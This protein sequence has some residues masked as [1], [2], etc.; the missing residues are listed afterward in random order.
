MLKQD[1]ELPGDEAGDGASPADLTAAVRRARLD[2]EQRGGIV[3]GLRQGEFARLDLLNARLRPVFAQV[4]PD[5]DIFDHGIVPGERPRCYID[6]LAFVEMERDRQ[7]YCFSVDTRRGR[8]TVVR[9]EQVEIIVAQVTDYV[10]RRLVE[11]ERMMAESRVIVTP[12]AGV[13]KEPV[14]AA[15]LAGPATPAPAPPGRR[16]DAGDI[17]FAIIMGLIGGAA[18]F[19]G[20]LW[21]MEWA[22]VARF[23]DRF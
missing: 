6:M 13:P 19:Q 3:A 20:A 12:S 21:L 16:F 15:N 23:L 18:L 4:P 10:A 7:T 8:V 11:R 17:V 22:P 14:E 9:S 5:I 2:D 1:E